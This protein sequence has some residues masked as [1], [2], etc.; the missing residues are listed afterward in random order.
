MFVTECRLFPVFPGQIGG[1]RRDRT[2]CERSPSEKLLCFR[3]PS[4]VC[5]ELFSPQGYH[6]AG[7]TGKGE[8]GAEG[9]EGWTGGEPG[10][11]LLF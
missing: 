4:P 10:A 6:G 7:Q 3:S 9:G 2:E 8:R 11:V 5:P 1:I